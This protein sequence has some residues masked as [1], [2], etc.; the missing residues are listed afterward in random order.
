[1]Q[2]PNTLDEA[3]AAGVVRLALAQF[4]SPLVLILVFGGVVSAMLRHWL[5][6]AV[7]LVVVLGSCSLGFLQEY[8]AWMAVAALRRRLALAVSAVCD[9]ARHTTPTCELVPGDVVVLSAGDLVPADGAVLEG[10]DFLVSEAS[11]TSESFPVEKS[12]GVL[13][14]NTPIAQRTNVVYLGTSVRCGMAK[15]VSCALASAPPSGLWRSNRVPR[16]PR[17]NSRAACSS[18]ACCS[19]A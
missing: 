13:P 19:C 12:P 1:M 2:G 4:K 11:L 17:P 14:A 5:D 15:V 10:R 8:R 3:S 16:R 18:S 9:G 6:A 7:I